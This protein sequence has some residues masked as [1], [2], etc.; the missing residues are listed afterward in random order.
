MLRCEMATPLGRPVDPDVN[1]TYARS[2]GWSRTAVEIGERRV[3]EPGRVRQSGE[4]PGRG[5]RIEHVSGSRRRLFGVDRHVRGTGGDDGVNRGELVE[6]PRHR[7]AHQVTGADT[8]GDESTREAV[9]PR[10]EFRIGQSRNALDEDGARVRCPLRS[11][12]NKIHE[13]RERQVP[14]GAA[15]ESGDGVSFAGQ[16]D[17]DVPDPRV[18][19]GRHGL[20]HSDESPRDALHGGAVEQVGA[21]A[22]AQPQPRF[23][24][25]HHGER[26]V[27]GVTGVD[28]GDAHAG[29]V[30]GLVETGAVDGV[31]LENSEGVEQGP[32]PM[33]C[34][35]LPRPT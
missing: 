28:T 31:R 26:V 15:F 25:G 22:H 14:L 35:M 6:R 7:D 9:D 18:G 16:E 17:V 12:R 23:Q 33:F 30:G 4:H 32:A 13:C 11:V 1:S 29:E 34:W 21:V 3:G 27:G 5:S 2:S 19:P 8:V 10:R 24:D 20:E